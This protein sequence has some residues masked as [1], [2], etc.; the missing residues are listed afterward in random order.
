MFHELVY[1]L[2]EM[3]Q[4]LRKIGHAFLV[5]CVH[6]RVKPNVRND[7]KFTPAISIA[8]VALKFWQLMSDVLNVG[9]KN[10]RG[11][12]ADRFTSTQ[13]SSGT[14]CPVVCGGNN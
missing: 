7:R 12:I 2:N 8:W 3:W 6:L 14:G 13:F 4:V 9:K 1:L 5:P 10:E 11:E